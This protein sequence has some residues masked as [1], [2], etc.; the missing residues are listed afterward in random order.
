MLPEITRKKEGGTLVFFQKNRKL[1]QKDNI[2]FRKRWGGVGSVGVWSAG[3]GGLAKRLEARLG[4][5][6]DLLPGTHPADFA[7]RPI[8][9][10]VI[11]PDATGLAGAGI[12]RPRLALLPGGSVALA[13]RVRAVSAVSYGLGRQNTLTLSSME[14]GS[15]SVAL[16]REL[17]TLSGSTVERQE[18]VL[19]YDR[20]QLTPEE[21]LCLSGALLLLDQSLA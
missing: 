14:G 19:P 7:Q 8:D 1:A 11:A 10:L 2:F 20:E 12:L 3:G 5:R 4:R 13:Q 17:V 18:W 6:F 21:L 15:V 16:Q 9:L